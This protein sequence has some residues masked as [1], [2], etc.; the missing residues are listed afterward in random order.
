[1]LKYKAEEETR[2]YKTWKTRLKGKVDITIHEDE[3]NDWTMPTYSYSIH[4]GLPNVLDIQ[5]RNLP[6]LDHAQESVKTMLE[7]LEICQV[8]T[9]AYLRL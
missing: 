2:V 7:R 8:I 5:E 1:M 4:R 9:E 3:I 6:T